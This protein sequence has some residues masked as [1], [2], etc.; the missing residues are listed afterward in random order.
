VKLDIGCGEVARIKEGYIGIDAY[1][2]DPNIKKANMDL[3]P[4]SDNSVQAIYSSHALEHMPK[5]RIVPTLKEWYRVLMPHG[6]LELFVPDLEWCIK[7]W[8]KYRTNDWHM[9][10]IFGKQEHAGEYHKTGFTKGLLTQYAIE[11]GFSVLEVKTINSHNQDTLA[12]RAIK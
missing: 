7:N 5:A 8:L 11:A 2:E 1:V 9:D 4:Y 10:T 12:L 6:L 3:L